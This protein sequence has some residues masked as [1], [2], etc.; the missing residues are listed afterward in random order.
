MFKPRLS[1][2]QRQLLPLDEL[3]QYRPRLGEAAVLIGLLEHEHTIELILTQRAA[4]LFSHPSEVAFPGGKFEPADR[5]LIA[6]ALREAQEETSLCP[7]RAS[8]LGALPARYTHAGIRVTAIVAQVAKGAALVA[9][10]SELSSIF[11]APVTLFQ[12]AQA[13]RLDVIEQRGVRYRVPAYVHQGYNI[14]GLTASLA[15]EVAQRFLAEPR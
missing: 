15:T 12:T 13:A 9:D 7:A 5:H 11:S 8:L 3:C 14:W 10:P 1:S 4:H 2:L 6:T